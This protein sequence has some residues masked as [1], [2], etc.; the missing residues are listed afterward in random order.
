MKFSSITS[1]HFFRLEKNSIATAVQLSD[2]TNKYCV[3]HKTTVLQLIGLEYLM[4]EF[5]FQQ[6]NE[7]L[8]KKINEEKEKANTEFKRLETQIHEVSGKF[9]QL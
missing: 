2:G 5:F 7:D 1:V 9:F 4:T 6:E 3:Y 8:V